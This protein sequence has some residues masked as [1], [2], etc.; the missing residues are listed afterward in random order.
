M[1]AAWLSAHA[2][3]SW[4]AAVPAV[5]AVAFLLV[6]LERR[7]DARFNMYWLM[8]SYAFIRRQVLGRTPELEARLDAQAAQVA[9]RLRGAQD[10]EVLVVGHSSGA[11]N[12]VQVVARALRLMGGTAQGAR[13]VLSLSTLD[14]PGQS[15]LPDHPKLLS[16][17]F[18]E[19]FDAAGYRSLKKDKFRMHFQYLMASER[20]VDYDY[21][22]ITAGARTLG[23]RFAHCESVRDYAGLRPFGAG[24]G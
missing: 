9:E 23:Q 17:R 21:F 14:V 3:G 16:P 13:P 22:R 11:N 12:A 6:L 5:A 2:T 10:D 8:R 24:L 15:P 1:L 4:L 20:A 7:L 18:A 19:M